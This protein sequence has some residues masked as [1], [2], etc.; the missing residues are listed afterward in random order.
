MVQGQVLGRDHVHL[1]R[2]SLVTE[3]LNSWALVP[4]AEEVGHDH[5]RTQSG[6]VAPYNNTV[7]NVSHD[8]KP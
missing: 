3:C 7:Q 2:G 4:P 5:V 6:R 1:T 8:L